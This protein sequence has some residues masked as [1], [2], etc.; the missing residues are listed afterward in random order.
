[1][2]NELFDKSFRPTAPEDGND[3]PRFGQPAETTKD[4]I[5]LGLRQ[6]FDDT[7]VAGRFAEN[8]TVEKYLTGFSAGT[9]PFATTVEIVQ[10]HPD[11]LESLPHLSVTVSNARNRRMTIGNL[12]I[13]QPQYP[14]RVEGTSTGPF[15]LSTSE[16][17]PPEYVLRYRTQPDRGGSWV[18]SSVVL[19]QSR[20]SDWTSA[21]VDDIVRVINEQSLYARSFVTPE[22]TIGIE[23]GGLKGTRRPN[24]IEIV[25]SPA[26]ALLG[27]SA[28]QRGTSFDTARPPRNRYHQ[29]TE[30]T[31]NIDVLS[32]DVNTRRELADLVYSWATF[33]L[34]RDHFELQG[35]TWSDEDVNEPEEWWHLV[36]HQEVNMGQFQTTDRVASAKDKLH[37]Q[38]VTIPVTLFQYLDRNVRFSDG[39]NW[40]AAPDTTRFD[41]TLPPKS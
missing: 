14:P 11:I 26:A 40:V 30:V 35:R 10:E 21:T 23:T 41:E 19:R 15:D 22:G 6:F 29:A 28:G 37:I 38:R 33:W 4:A 32:V 2:S 12:L 31:V 34:E 20:F 27:F 16:A 25:D 7:Q 3:P 39:R 5:V 17:T 24:V 1:M 18:E 13:G 8:P 36:I 9:D